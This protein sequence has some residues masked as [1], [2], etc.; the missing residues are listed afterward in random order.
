MAYEPDKD[1]VLKEV[2]LKEGEFKVQL[3]SYNGGEHK[4]GITRRFFMSEGKVGYTSKTGRV[5]KEDAIAI[6]NAILEITK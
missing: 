5:E 1:K 2:E 4:V 3:C 6:A